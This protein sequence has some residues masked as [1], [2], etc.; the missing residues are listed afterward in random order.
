MILWSQIWWLPQV[1]PRNIF[2]LHGVVIVIGDNKG[3]ITCGGLTTTTTTRG[4]GK[5]FLKPIVF[6]MFWDT[7]SYF[8]PSSQARNPVLDI[9]L[10]DF[11]EDNVETRKTVSQIFQLT[12]ARWL[13]M[14][15]FVISYYGSFLLENWPKCKGPSKNAERL[16]ICM[17][18]KFDTT[19]NHPLLW[20]KRIDPDDVW[21]CWTCGK[22]YYSSTS[23]L[24]TH[25]KHKHPPHKWWGETDGRSTR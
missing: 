22:G 18:V 19:K 16:Q 20:C 25:S 9:E 7:S 10:M 14:K 23:T 24:K 1:F 3:L 5:N 12:S 8:T 11:L 13:A 17:I 6:D 2:D 15:C 21:Q 4:G